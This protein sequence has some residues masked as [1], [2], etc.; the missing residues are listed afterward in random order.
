MTSTMN[1]LQPMKKISS[2]NTKTAEGGGILA[3]PS[4]YGG[5]MK[6]EIWKDIPGYED[7]YQASTLGRIRS[8]DRFFE[9]KDWRTGNIT[10]VHVNEKVL[11]AGRFNAHGHLSVFLRNQQQPDGVGKPV[12]QL[13]ML[14]F[15]GAAKDGCEVLHKNGNPKD[16]RLENLCYGTRSENMTDRYRHAQCGLKLTVSDVKA[17]RVMLQNGVPQRQIARCFGVSDTTIYYIKK[18]RHFQ[19]VV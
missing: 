14:T 5:L 2:V 6:T 11:T 7:R 16:N 1:S 4:L 19:W 18:E 10:Q 3:A 8:L 15:V 13:I 12:H 17:I 9:R